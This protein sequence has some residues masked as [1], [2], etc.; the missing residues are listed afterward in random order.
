MS[1]FTVRTRKRSELVCITKQVARC[2]EKSGV[3]D[4]IA[5]VFCPHTTAGI[6][7]NENADPDVPS[8]MVMKLEKLIEREDRDYRH[9]EG[10]SDSHVKSTLTGASETVIIRE[11]RLVLGTWQG[12][13]FTEFD[14]PR[15]RSVHVKV[16][17]G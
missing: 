1:N 8:D 5:V 16:M 3:R 15:T 2:V 6:T 17:A 10:N 4:G 9:N 11:G 14:G 7:I 13:Y 12:I